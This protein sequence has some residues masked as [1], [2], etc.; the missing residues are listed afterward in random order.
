MV[1]L[2]QNKLS[3]E[4]TFSD[5]KAIEII[6]S[7]PVDQRETIIEKYIIL[8]D[9]VVTHASI[10]TSKESIDQFFAPLARASADLGN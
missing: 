2:D 9:M 1:I 10:S 5:P 6:Q 7:L 8:G 4:I 3:L